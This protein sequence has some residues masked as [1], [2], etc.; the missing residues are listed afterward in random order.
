MN[1]NRIFIFILL[2][3]LL[4]VLYRYQ[5]QIINTV[6]PKKKIK[7]IEQSEKKDKKKIVKIKGKSTKELDKASLDGVSQ[8]SLGSLMGAK[9]IKTEEIYNPASIVHTDE[10]SFLDNDSKDSFL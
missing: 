6:I 2:V 4:Y 7:K 3:A 9:S 10:L 1:I 5:K 8:G